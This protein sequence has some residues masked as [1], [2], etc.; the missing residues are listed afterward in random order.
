MCSRRRSTSGTTWR[1]TFC[2]ATATEETSATA[3]S[4]RR[5][6]LYSMALNL[7]KAVSV[8][9]SA[10]SFLSLAESRVLNA[11]SFSITN[12]K[13]KILLDPVGDEDV[14][15]ALDL[16]VAVRG[17]GEFLPVGREHGEAIEGRVEGY[18]LQTCAVHI[19]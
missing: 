15:V 7:F 2:R 8:Q 1:A 3:R 14:R 12:Q 18:L 4:R 9:H 13:S 17:E 11:D 6:F 19:H 16:S 10:F 5:L